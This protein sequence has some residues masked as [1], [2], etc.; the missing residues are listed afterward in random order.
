MVGS[1]LTGQ[2]TDK[3]LPKKWPNLVKINKNTHVLENFIKNS[4]KIKLL[5]NFSKK[6]LICSANYD[7][8]VPIQGF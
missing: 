6:V 8:Y 3:F 5:Y 4:K 1:T 7:K 2:N